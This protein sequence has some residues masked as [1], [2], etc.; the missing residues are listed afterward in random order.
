MLRIFFL[1]FLI[2]PFT[3]ALDFK[4]PWIKAVP[5]GQKISAGYVEIVNNTQKDISLIKVESDIAEYSELHT[6]FKKEGM[7]RMRQVK[8]IVIKSLQS[9]TLKPLSYHIMLIQ[10]KRPLIK[11]ES[12]PI[13]LIFADQSKYKVDFVVR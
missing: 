2:C 6:H 10:L 1:F 7:M 9:Q 4:D 12:I 11:G 13:T 5:K 3:F 8:N